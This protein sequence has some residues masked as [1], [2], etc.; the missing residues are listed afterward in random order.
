MRR[1]SRSGG[2]SDAIGAR[3]ACN[4]L[5][6]IFFQHAP[7]QTAMR[8]AKGDATLEELIGRAETPTALRLVAEYAAR[9]LATVKPDPNAPK[10]PP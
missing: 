6:A 7:S 9:N 5:G 3:H 2:A 4:A 10:P 8:D 1:Y